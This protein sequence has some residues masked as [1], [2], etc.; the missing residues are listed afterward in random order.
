MILPAKGGFH[1]QP[2]QTKFRGKLIL[3][4]TGKTGDF[5]GWYLRKISKTVVC[6]G[7]T[8]PGFTQAV[9]EEIENRLLA[10]PGFVRS[11]YLGR[12]MGVPVCVACRGRPGL[13]LR[14]NFYCSSLAHRFH[15]IRSIPSN[16]I[17]NRHDLISW[18][19]LP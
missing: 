15:Y 11:L 8:L 13:S 10:P 18:V 2:W 9:D 19:Q 4:S 5:W 17:Q 12:L 1:G 14:F 7:F 16:G 3:R 6:P